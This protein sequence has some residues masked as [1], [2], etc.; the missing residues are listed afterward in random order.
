MPLIFAIR[1]DAE[2]FAGGGVAVFAAAVAL[3]AAVGGGDA[4]G[5]SAGDSVVPAGDGFEA[6]VFGPSTTAAPFK[7]GRGPSWFFTRI[8]MRR[9][10]GSSGLL[11]T[12]NSWSA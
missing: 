1:P 8:E 6:G 12:R 11:F 4:G 3:F 2:G 10:D 9:F 5:A 7:L